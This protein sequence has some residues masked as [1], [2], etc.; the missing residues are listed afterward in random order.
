MKAQIKKY[1]R[2]AK[3][4]FQQLLNYN[5]AIFFI[6]LALVYGLK[7]NGLVQIVSAVSIKVISNSN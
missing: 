2:I 5:V 7:K 6:K 3:I 1:V 4:L